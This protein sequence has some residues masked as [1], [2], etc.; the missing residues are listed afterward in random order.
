MIAG[1]RAE[2]IFSGYLLRLITEAND[3]LDIGTSERFAKELRSYE[4][5]FHGKR[6]IAAG[7]NPSTEK[8][9]YNCDC[10]QNIEMMTFENQ[11]FDAVICLEV[12]EHVANPFQ[13]VS[14]IKRV[15]RKGGKL[16]LTVPFLSQYHGKTSLSHDH[17]NYPDYWRFTHE[18]LHKLFHDL[19]KVEIHPLDGPI[20]FRLKQFRL[21]KLVNYRV[22]RKIIDSIDKP[23]RGKATTR[24]LV[25]GV[26]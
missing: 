12:L 3:I 13:A 19:A 1:G 8:G 24:H 25:Y 17:D 21:S 14:E 23:T 11:S 5:L 7:Y 15:L 18:G 26:K 4:N 16:L 22:I 9:K 20:E 2:A 6:Y 10:H